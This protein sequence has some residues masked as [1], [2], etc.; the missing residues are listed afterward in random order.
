MATAAL[1]GSRKAALQAL[2]LDP[3]VNSLERAEG[4]LEDMLARQ[5]DLPELR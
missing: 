4:L 1:T 5:D 2:L 3:N